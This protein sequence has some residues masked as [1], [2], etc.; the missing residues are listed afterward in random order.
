LLKSWK[1]KTILKE[2]K[3][4]EMDLGYEKES[5]TTLRQKQYKWLQ[6]RTQYEE[7]KSKLR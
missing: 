4:K 6:L 7:L 1:D 5:K 2:K 3:Y